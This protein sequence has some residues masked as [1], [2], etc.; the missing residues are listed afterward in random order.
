MLALAAAATEVAAEN[1]TDA[2]LVEGAILLLE[3]RGE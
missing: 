1:A 3:R 2:A